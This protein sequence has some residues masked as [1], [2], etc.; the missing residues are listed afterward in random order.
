MSTINK[1]RKSVLLTFI[2]V[3]V[4][5]LASCSSGGYG[6]DASPKTSNF[7]YSNFTDKT[8]LDPFETA[9]GDVGATMESL[10]QLTGIGYEK[11]KFSKSITWLTENTDL[12]KS[13]GLI[14]QFIFTAHAVGFSEEKTVSEQLAILKKVIAADGTVP[15]TNNFSYSWVVLGLLAAGENDLAAKVSKK[16]FSF[17]EQDGGLKYA[18][19]DTASPTA[20]DVTAFALM[21]F[22]ATE[23]LGSDQDKAATAL[24]ISRTKNWL[25]S[26]KDAGNFWLMDGDIDISGTAYAI[27]ALDAVGDD[28]TPSIKWLTSQVGK[29]GGLATAWSAPDSDLFSTNQSILALSGLNF[30]DVLNNSKQ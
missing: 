17:I 23:N 24:A 12:L 16:L 4:L 5:A 7:V 30:L 9:S 26:R 29:D 8:F 10:V 11:S 1:L 19:G 21:S 3:A 27:M 25:Q 18:F 28:V 2:S 15:D 14:G 6:Q 13:P 20:T 22:K